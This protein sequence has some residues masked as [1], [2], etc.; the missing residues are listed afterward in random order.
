MALEIPGIYVRTDLGS[1]Y[2]FDHIDLKAI[3][4]SGNNTILT[5]HNPT[6]FDAEVTVFAENGTEAKAPLHDNAFLNWKQKVNVKAGKTTTV[7]V[8]NN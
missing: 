3:K 2:V 7:K 1:A 6:Q 5:L 4:Q 8:K